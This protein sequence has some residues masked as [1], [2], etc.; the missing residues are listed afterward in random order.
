MNA[1]PISIAMVECARYIILR[2]VNISP[3][4]VTQS[5]FVPGLPINL[6]AIVKSPGKSGHHS[7]SGCRCSY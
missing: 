2:D 1:A 6:D 7:T 5:R 3:V 4:D